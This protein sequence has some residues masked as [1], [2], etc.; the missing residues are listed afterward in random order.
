L[1]F[2][3]KQGHD[4]VAYS[5]VDIT[6]DDAEGLGNDDAKSI[7]LTEG[8]ACGEENEVTDRHDEE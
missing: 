3:V 4:D 6:T 5:E 1:L 2:E 8:P 7:D